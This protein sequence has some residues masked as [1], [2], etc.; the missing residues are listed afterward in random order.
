MMFVSF[1]PSPMGIAL[2]KQKETLNGV[3]IF[4]SSTEYKSAL[5]QWDE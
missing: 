1:L 2:S 3:R 5:C 4:M